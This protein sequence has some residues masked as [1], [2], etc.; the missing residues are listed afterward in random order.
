MDLSEKRMLQNGSVQS[1]R[2][3]RLP[4]RNRSC[5][6]TLIC[7]YVAPQGEKQMRS[8]EQARP[9]RCRG[10][11]WAWRGV[12]WRGCAHRTR[13]RAHGRARTWATNAAIRA[14]TVLLLRWAIS[15]MAVLSAASVRSVP[16]ADA[17]PSSFTCSRFGSMARGLLLLWYASAGVRVCTHS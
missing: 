11:H 6:R 4:R 15:F 17:D 5:A 12:A 7:T 9:V 1:T 16:R 2:D 13:T 3:M 10:R 14:D 8:S